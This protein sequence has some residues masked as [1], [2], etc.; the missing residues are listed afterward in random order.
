[1]IDMRSDLLCPRSPH[2][3]EAMRAATLKSPALE[4]GEDAHERGL[5]TTLAAELGVEAVL[6]TPTCTMANQ[7]AIRL[8]VPA[9]GRLVSAQDAHVVTVEARATALTGVSSHALAADNGHLA[10]KTVVGFLSESAMD[11]ATLVWLENTHMLSAG[12][13]MPAGL[14]ATIG[15]ACRSAGASIH[16]DG[17]RLWNAAAALNTPMAVLV[18]GADTVAVSLNKAV[19]APLGSVL[20]GSEPQI[21]EATRLRDAMGGQ[22]RPIGCLAAAALAALEGWRPRLETDHAIAKWLAQAIAASLGE[23]AVRPPQTNL[24]FLN[25]PLGDARGFVEA[26]GREGVGSIAIG[27]RAVRLAVHSGVRDAEAAQVAV[28]VQRADAAQRLSA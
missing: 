8:H 20:A 13:I 7:I 4:P 24:I 22:W 16:L 18:E 26:L 19:G 10:L 14:Q 5:L 27:S 21:V 1:M 17:S 23:E 2:I 25:R 12:S 3:A 6:F 15:S 11:E 9:G 28:A